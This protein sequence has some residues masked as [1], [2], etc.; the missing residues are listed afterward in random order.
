MI[1]HV[2]LSLL[3]LLPQKSPV[4]AFLALMRVVGSVYKSKPAKNCLLFASARETPATIISFPDPDP[5]AG[6]GLVTFARFVDC[7]RSA[8]VRLYRNVM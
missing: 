6:K 7:V 8:I 5:H 4:P 1:G 3:S 2:R